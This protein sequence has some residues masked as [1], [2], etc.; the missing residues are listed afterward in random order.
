[1]QRPENELTRL[2]LSMENEFRGA[3]TYKQKLHMKET[4]I[5]RS[6]GDS[7]REKTKETDTQIR[8]RHRETCN[9]RDIENF[10]RHSK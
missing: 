5:E 10:R 4:D 7:Y 3:K 1:M 6:S 2:Y 9:K 8:D